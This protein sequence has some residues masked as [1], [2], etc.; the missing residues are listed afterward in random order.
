MYHVPDLTL[1]QYSDLSSKNSSGLS[2]YQDLF[3][4]LILSGLSLTSDISDIFDYL[5]LERSPAFPPEIIIIW[6]KSK[7]LPFFF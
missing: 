1:P 7:P 5:F 6:G 3:S 4:V 2:E